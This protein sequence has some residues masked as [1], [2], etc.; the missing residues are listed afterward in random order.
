MDGDIDEHLLNGSVSL[1]PEV[2]PAIAPLEKMRAYCVN[3]LQFIP[4]VTEFGIIISDNI[5]HR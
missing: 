1:G 3:L 2:S 5:R 4:A